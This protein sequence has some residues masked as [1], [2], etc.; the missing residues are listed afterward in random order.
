MRYYVISDIHGNLEALQAVLGDIAKDEK[1]EYLCVG[2][3]VGYCAD[4]KAVIGLVRSL[5]PKLSVAGNHDWG[6]LGEL[7]LEYFNEY[8]IK[9]ILWTRNILNKEELD[10]LGSFKLVREEKE[11]TLVHGSLEEPESFNYIF[12]C[13]DAYPTS[14]CLKTCICFVGHSHV[15]GI[16]HYS[17]GKSS[18]AR[19]NKIKIDCNDKYVINVG[20]V[21]QP[22]DHDPRASYA[23]YDD[24]EGV[25]EIRRVAYDIKSAQAKI[26][27]CALPAFLASRLSDGA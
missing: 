11:I 23:V 20:S 4:P 25:I 19:G 6:V 17:T 24:K 3:V 26:L 16:Y 8:A 1:G 7:D 13:E 9:A 21:G 14:R 12:D 18:Q 22:R 27:K 15:P 10:Y 5:R 2:D